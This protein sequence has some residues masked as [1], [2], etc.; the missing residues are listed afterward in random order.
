M[1]IWYRRVCSQRL[2]NIFLLMQI[3]EETNRNYDCEYD[4]LVLRIIRHI[5]VGFIWLP[6]CPEIRAIIKLSS[7][8]KCWQGEL[9]HILM[10][11][12]KRSVVREKP[13]A[14]I[15]CG[16]GKSQIPEFFIYLIPDFFGIGKY[17]ILEF[18]ILNPW[19]NEI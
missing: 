11:L 5:Y 8:R 1:D 18:F 10:C 7:P 14:V 17:R 4:L 19:S 13:Y 12:L 6:Y 3:L 2:S 15:F 9:V 16:M